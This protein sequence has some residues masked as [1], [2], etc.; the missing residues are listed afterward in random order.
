MGTVDDRLGSALAPFVGA[1]VAGMVLRAAAREIGK[2]P[3]E[4][5]AEDLREVNAI[6]IRLLSP[7]MSVATAQE[8]LDSAIGEV[9]G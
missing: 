4:L 3:G 8:V 1:V 2:E 5:L 9:A 7:V 6:L